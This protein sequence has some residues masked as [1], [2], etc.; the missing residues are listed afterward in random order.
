MTTQD[1]FNTIVRKALGEMAAVPC[2]ID[3]YIEGLSNAQDLF[4][5]AILASR[6]DLEGE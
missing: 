4:R 6:E 2:S 1:K 5:E 3:E